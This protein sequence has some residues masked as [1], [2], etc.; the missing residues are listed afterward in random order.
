MIGELFPGT[1]RKLIGYMLEECRILLFYQTYQRIQ[2]GPDGGHG[3]QDH[4]FI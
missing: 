1:E 2:R 3:G 4:H